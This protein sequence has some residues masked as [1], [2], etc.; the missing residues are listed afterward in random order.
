[1]LGLL[2]IIMVLVV[3][4]IECAPKQV[5]RAHQV[6]D[7]RVCSEFDIFLQEQQ[8]AFMDTVKAIH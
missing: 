7:K 5:A 2:P 6:D 1:M 4:V 3:G 8:K